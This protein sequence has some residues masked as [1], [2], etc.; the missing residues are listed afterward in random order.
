MQS[1]C[2]TSTVKI[3]DKNEAEQKIKCHEGNAR[4]KN[5]KRPQICSL[6]FNTHILK[7]NL[8]ISLCLF[9]ET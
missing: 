2:D 3:S 4:V 5:V 6:S 9:L 8:H 1:G 7:L